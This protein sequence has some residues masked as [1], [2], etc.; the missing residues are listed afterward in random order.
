[1]TSGILKAKIATN[2]L[3]TIFAT[4]RTP[5]RISSAWKSHVGMPARRSGGATKAKSRSCTVCMLSRCS[6]L[7]SWIGEA[8]AMKSARTPRQKKM[9]CL[10][11]T[12]PASGGR[13][14]QTLSA[15]Q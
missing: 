6:S 12:G 2:G 9:T 5:L 10:C 11:E 13:G 3:R 1:M 8:P 15:Y 7:M 4:G 14:R